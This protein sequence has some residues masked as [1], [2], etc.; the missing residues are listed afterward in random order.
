MN[1]QNNKKIQR[2]F[3]V[4]KQIKFRAYIKR[5][6]EKKTQQDIHI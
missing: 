6:E 2:L 4:E 3:F 5:N 1:F